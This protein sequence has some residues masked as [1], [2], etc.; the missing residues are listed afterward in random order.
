MKRSCNFS[1]RMSLD[2]LDKLENS[3]K[4][5]KFASVSEALRSYSEVG[6]YVESYKTVIKDP[7]FLKSIEEL[8]RTEGVFHWLETLTDE[9]AD[10]ITTALKMEKEKR[11]GTK[12]FR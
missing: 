1:I 2:F 9:Q 6:M 7:E 8:K 4:S 3:V 5:G 10:A 11:F 12:S